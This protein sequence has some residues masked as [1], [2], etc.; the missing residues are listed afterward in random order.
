MLNGQLKNVAIVFV[1]TDLARTHRFYSKTLGIP[2]EVEDFE[3]GYLQAR[4]PGDVELVFLPGDAA[5][6]A[7]PQVVFGLARGGIDTMVASLA[8]AGVE[9][10]TPV[11]EAPGGWSAELKDPDGHI[12]SL[13]QD[14]SLPR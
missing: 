13:Y 11:S 14:G 10:V 9:L 12:L 1:V 8:A 4:L 6:G 3:N 5:R 2:F 7:T